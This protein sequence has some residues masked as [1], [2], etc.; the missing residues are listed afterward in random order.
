MKI[1]KIK[2]T[3]CVLWVLCVSLLSASMFVLTADSQVK[4][5]KPPES[6]KPDM[7]LI[8]RFDKAIHQRFLTKPQLGMRR[9]G[10]QPNPHLERFIPETDDEKTSVTDFQN[11]G[12]KVGLYLFGR[13]AN[14]ITITKNGKSGKSLRILNKLNNPLPVTEK[15]KVKNL[16]SPQ[17]LLEQVKIAF[18]EFQ[19]KDSYEFDLGKKS[20]I[21]R[22]VRA[23][24]E[25]CLGCHTDFLITEI[26]AKG[27]YKYRPRKI[28]DTIGVLVYSFE[29]TKQ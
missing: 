9:I 14:E 25:T 16:T 5:K 20:F 21:A 26:V 12:W 2:I 28:G 15:L 22:P 10:P 18:L 4:D 8:D 1:I 11:D 29:K 24:N 27:T 6:P 19:K 17:K 23:A 3:I 13:R 7:E